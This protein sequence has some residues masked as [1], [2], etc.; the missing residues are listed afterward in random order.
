[1]TVNVKD[2]GAVGDNTTDNFV[3]FTSAISNIKDIGGILYFP[4]DT[5]NYFLGTSIKIP[6]NIELQF[7]KG[8]KIKLGNRVNI[9]GNFTK[10][11]AGRFQIFDTFNEGGLT[12]TWE[13]DKVYPEWW[14]AESDNS[15]INDEFVRKS[16][17]FCKKNYYKCIE[18]GQGTYLFDGTYIVLDR[19][20]S[21]MQIMGQCHNTTLKLKD[22][23]SGG[24]I[25]VISNFRDRES[26]NANIYNIRIS[27]MK[28][29]GN[30]TAATT[31]WFLQTWINGGIAKIVGLVLD[32]L[33]LSNFKTSGF[34][35]ENCYNCKITNIHSS[36]NGF[37]GLSIANGSYVL[38]NIWVNNNSDYGI[39]F[40]GGSAY[41]IALASNI[42][43]EKNRVGMKTAGFW[44]LN[45]SNSH[46]NDNS[47][48]AVT[49]TAPGGRYNFS[50]IM[51]RNNG[52]PS[53]N[54][55]SGNGTEKYNIVNWHSESDNKTM[56]SSNGSIYL[57]GSVSEIHGTNITVL[58]SGNVGVNVSC[59]NTFLTAVTV[60]GNN[61][62]YPFRIYNGGLIAS[63]LMV[64]NNNSLLV[65]FGMQISTDYNVFISNS[66]IG[67]D[68]EIKLQTRGIAIG[69]E[70]S[71]IIIIKTTDFTECNTGEGVTD[72]S[73]SAEVIVEHSPN[74][75]V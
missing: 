27:R 21:G 45:L 4:H 7:A 10:L 35:L 75:G 6:E 24:H 26:P 71:G 39:N 37:H 43:S 74:S 49:K 66:K 2:F 5:G 63:G 46:F 61:N 1:M 38:N 25:F 48:E 44:D 20:C 56:L 14:G 15:T 16:I 41:G 69:S 31:S 19:T 73:V 8:G 30:T 68:R 57:S 59:K 40:T 47:N 64:Y 29:V 53:L 17:E 52:G 9:E 32:E 36:N 3:A 34:S 60:R 65:P 33:D 58:D 12:G 42:F 18:F 22:N 70:C 28:A 50:N 55:T 67:D 51:T 13:V 72:N 23:A 11:R 54:A 62:S